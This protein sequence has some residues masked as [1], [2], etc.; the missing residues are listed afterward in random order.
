MDDDVF[1]CVYSWYCAGFEITLLT[2]QFGEELIR[3]NY[4]WL[5]ETYLNYPRTIM[6]VD[7]ARIAALHT[8]GGFYAD[9]NICM[10]CDPRYEGTRRLNEFRNSCAVKFPDTQPVGVSND[11]IIGPKNHPFLL[12][13]LIRYMH[14][15]TLPSYAV[16]Y[17]DVMMKTGP[18]IVSTLVH[19]W[20]M[21]KDIE[22]IEGYGNNRDAP[23][24]RSNA[25]SSWHEW[26]AF[27][28]VIVW[29]YLYYLIVLGG[30]VVVLGVS[31]SARESL[32]RTMV[33][34]RRITRS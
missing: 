14:E 16:N 26:D 30:I 10:I 31:A 28:I 20:P 4:P 27:F 2:D 25:G 32:A 18:M 13:L 22:I 11:F 23:M 1:D 9:S 34:V 15:A 17:L 3:D 5:Y 24:I 29:D 7:V 21:P 19:S 8:Y 6:R 33:S 12:H